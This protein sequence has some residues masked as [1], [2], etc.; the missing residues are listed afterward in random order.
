MLYLYIL[1]S[2]YLVPETAWIR[3]FMRF[4]SKVFFPTEWSEAESLRPLLNHVA[5]IPKIPEY[6]RRPLHGFIDGGVCREQAL[7]QSFSMR[8]IMGMFQ[9]DPLYREISFSNIMSSLTVPEDDI[10]IDIGCGSG[11][12]TKALSENLPNNPVIGVD[13]SRS[14][15]KLAKRRTKLTYITADAAL[16]PLKNNSAGIVT[17]FAL[18][19]EMPKSYSKKVMKEV[20]RVVKPNGYFL[21]WDQNPELITPQTSSSIPIEPFLDSYKSMNMSEEL[22]HIGFENLDIITDKFMR[23]WICKKK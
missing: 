15:T 5:D 11:D 19:H 16:L 20:L 3:H 13:L 17:A 18:F 12:S 8:Y 22:N 4:N 6:F 23:A 21:I 2:S 14:M 9:C 10:A 1:I 7:Q